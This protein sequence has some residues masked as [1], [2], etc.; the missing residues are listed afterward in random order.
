MVNFENSVKTHSWIINVTGAKKESNSTQESIGM[1]TRGCSFWVEFAW[2]HIL[3]MRCTVCKISWVWRSKTCLWGCLLGNELERLSRGLTA[4]DLVVL[5][6]LALH[7]ML[8]EEN[9]AGSMES[10]C[11]YIARNLNYETDGRPVPSLCLLEVERWEMFIRAEAISHSNV[12]YPIKTSFL[13]YYISKLVRSGMGRDW[14]PQRLG[15]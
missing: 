5:R 3:S 9:V 13:I 12:G 8:A 4:E 14:R 15:Q 1:C 2:M 7:S 6:S 11:K 10:S